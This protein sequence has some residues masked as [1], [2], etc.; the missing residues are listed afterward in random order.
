MVWIFGIVLGIVAL[1]VERW[2]FKRTVAKPEET[3]MMYGSDPGNFAAKKKL[4]NPYN[5]EKN[6]VTT[7]PKAAN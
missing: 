7:K 1:L 5:K 3:T 6:K 4:R 2:H